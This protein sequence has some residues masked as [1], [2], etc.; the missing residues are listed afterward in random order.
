MSQ[1][2]RGVNLQTEV[3]EELALLQAEVRLLMKKQKVDY[4]LSKT[5][6][7]NVLTVLIKN[8]NPEELAKLLK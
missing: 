5:A 8:A 3:Y 6:M 1:E 4:M 7:T 2:R